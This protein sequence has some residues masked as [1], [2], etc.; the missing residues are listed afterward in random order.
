MIDIIGNAVLGAL[1]GMAA[2]T[3]GYLKTESGRYKKL[4][5][6][7]PEKFLKT[8]LLGGV[9]GAVAGAQGVSFEAAENFLT[10]VGVYGSISLFVDAAAKAIWR[11]AQRLWKYLKRR[12]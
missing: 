8:T 9:V 5:E 3:V 2:A 11:N 4:E 10:M 1:G 12:F 7:D 6:F